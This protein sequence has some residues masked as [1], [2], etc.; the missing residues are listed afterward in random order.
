[1]KY[2]IIL[3][4]F[5]YSWFDVYGQL[6]TIRLSE[7]KSDNV[8]IIGSFEDLIRLHGTSDYIS[9]NNQFNFYRKGVYSTNK[10]TVLYFNVLYFHPNF[11]MCY[12]EKDGRVRLKYFDFK[13]NKKAVIYIPKIKLHRKLKLDEVIQAYQIPNDSIVKIKRGIVAGQKECYV[14]WLIFSTGEHERVMLELDFDSK[15]KLRFMSIGAYD[16]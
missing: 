2:F 1:M 7:M 14:Y 6:D 9:E 11:K 15:K 4:F 10:D 16:F 8:L 3:I 5:I 12:I 13:L